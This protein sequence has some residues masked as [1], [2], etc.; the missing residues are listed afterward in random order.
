[1]I[2]ESQEHISE[3]LH[4]FFLAKLELKYYVVFNN[5]KK[6]QRP[7]DNRTSVW[8]VIQDFEVHEEMR[9]FKGPVSCRFSYLLCHN[10]D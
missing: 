7:K 3:V 1:M 4:W 10:F 8:Q 6:L 2:I 9:A 5:D